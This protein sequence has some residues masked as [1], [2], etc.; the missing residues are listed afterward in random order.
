[1]YT[2]EE[3]VKTSLKDEQMQ[4]IFSLIFLK[5]LTNFWFNRRSFLYFTV[6]NDL[7]RENTFDVR[8]NDLFRCVHTLR[9]TSRQIYHLNKYQNV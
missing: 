5:F 1:M 4:P 7:M 8:K 9:V 6:R 2:K 3:S